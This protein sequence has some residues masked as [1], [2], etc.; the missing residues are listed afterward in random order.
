[1]DVFNADPS[2]L[3]SVGDANYLEVQRTMSASYSD[4]STDPT[5]MMDN[6]PPPDDPDHLDIDGVD[7]RT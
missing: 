3:F 4:S 1:M 5:A 7:V 6:D 2:K